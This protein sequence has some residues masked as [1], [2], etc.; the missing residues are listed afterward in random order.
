MILVDTSVWIEY[1]RR[2][3]GQLSELL[4]AGIVIGHPFVAGEVACGHLRNRIEVLELFQR[5][6]QAPVVPHAEAL[7]LI[8]RGRL[9]GQGL[10]WI[11]LH[12]LA[13][14]LSSGCSLWSF[15]TTRSRSA[16]ALGIENS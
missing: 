12:L 16:E 8:E 2:G 15:D 11:D 14:A 3:D 10:G 4:D 7:G 1:L 6:P 5:L 9:Y 13:S